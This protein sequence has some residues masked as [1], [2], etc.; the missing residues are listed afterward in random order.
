MRSRSH[1]FVGLN[2]DLT[3][4]NAVSDVKDRQSSF[5]PSDKKK[6]IQGSKLKYRSVCVYRLIGYRSDLSGVRAAD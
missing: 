6:T 3:L 4:R 5:S 2:R 1:Q